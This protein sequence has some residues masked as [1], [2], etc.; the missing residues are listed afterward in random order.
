MAV[1]IKVLGMH[2]ISVC[3][4]DNE[5]LRANMYVYVTLKI[6][7]AGEKSLHVNGRK[8]HRYEWAFE[9]GSYYIALKEYI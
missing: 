9:L 5:Y 7:D 3:V 4:C 1:L 8:L 6:N 2:K